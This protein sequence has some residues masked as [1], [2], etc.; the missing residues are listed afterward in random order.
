M[1][2]YDMAYVVTPWTNREERTAVVWSPQSPTLARWQSFGIQVIQTE[3]T[4]V[5]KPTTK[6][7]TV[8]KNG[9]GDIA[10]KKEVPQ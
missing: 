10:W 5:Q 1:L 6:M 3:A 4:R 2:R 8:E 7:W 9:E